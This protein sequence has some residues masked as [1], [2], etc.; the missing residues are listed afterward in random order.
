MW[1][2]CSVTRRWACYFS[3]FSQYA[4]IAQYLNTFVR[5]V[6]LVWQG[7]VW[8][9]AGHGTFLHVHNMY[10]IWILQHFCVLSALVRLRCSVTG[11]WAWYADFSGSLH[12]L[13]SLLRLTCQTFKNFKSCHER[14]WNF[15]KLTNMGAQHLL[16]LLRLTIS[17]PFVRGIEVWQVN[18]RRESR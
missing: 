16:S 10:N 8:L 6:S 15:Q 12:H 4:Q 3:T 5:V 7:A 1:L 13:L 2:R 14:N 11:R 9:G 17:I 18:L